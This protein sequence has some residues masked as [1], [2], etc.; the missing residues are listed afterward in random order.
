MTIT[1]RDAQHAYNFYVLS[2]NHDWSPKVKFLYHVKF[3][4]RNGAARSVSKNLQELG[5]LAKTVEMP[6]FSATIETK[7]QYNRKKNVQTR[8]DYGE[9]RIV[10]H[11][12]NSD[13]THALMREYY[14]YYYRDGRNSL[15]NSYGTRDAYSNS[16]Q[17]YGLD[18]D[19]TDTFFESIEIYQLSRGDWV[20][21]KLI[22][23]LVSQWGHDNLDYSDGA[24]TTEN[25]MAIMYEG[26]I[27]DS[28]TGGGDLLQSIPG[29]DLEAEK[30]VGSSISSQVPNLPRRRLGDQGVIFNESQEQFAQYIDNT[31]P[32]NN[33]GN[34]IVLTNFIRDLA[35]RENV[36][37]QVTPLP[38][39]TPVSAS[40]RNTS[41]GLM[42]SSDIISEFNGND[43]L[44]NSFIQ[45]A[46]STGSYTNTDIF[47][48]TVFS[49]LGPSSREF[50]KSDII[51]KLRSGDL[52][53]ITLGSDLIRNGGRL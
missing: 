36:T 38:A 39:T 6:Q 5:K 26:V 13:L 49:N 21:Y 31:V 53:L 35:N 40:T 23:P 45:S 10:F 20:S 25:T 43:S 51:S 15:S 16:V 33:T 1:L 18:N 27:Y 47:T 28:G 46:I 3:N 41:V 9:I 29:Y 50:I 32:D 14:N 7:Q 42:S 34:S 30:E 4:I 44:F 37:S 17:R 2:G 48:T 52:R 11:D 8:I 24:G 19:R 22:N 12:D